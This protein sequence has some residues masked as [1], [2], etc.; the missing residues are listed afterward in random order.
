MW[1][2]AAR[3]TPPAAPPLEASDSGSQRRRWV[4]RIRRPDL[5]WGKEVVGSSSQRRSTPERKKHSISFGSST[6]RPLP[7]I[8][9]GG[10]QFPTIDVAA[11]MAALVPLEN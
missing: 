6:G 8:F 10:K 4:V 9:T 2:T 1:E 7:V 5:R 11:K 3:G